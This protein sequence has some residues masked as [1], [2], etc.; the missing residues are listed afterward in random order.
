MFK[1]DYI[2]PRASRTLKQRHRTSSCGGSGAS[3]LPSTLTI[4]VGLPLLF[5][6]GAVGVADEAATET[7]TA[8]VTPTEV[9][10][11]E[12]T[13]ES[14]EA[15]ATKVV[16]LLADDASKIWQHFCSKPEVKLEDVW[17]IVTV[18][19]ERHLICKGDPK[20]FLYTK[21]QYDNFEL[22]FEWT[23][24]SDPNGNSGVL[25]Y[26]QKELRLW[27]TS[28]QVQLHQPEAGA[29]FASGD[30][31]SD[32]PFDA[33]VSAKPAEW[34][35]CRIVS[36]GGRLSVEI[37]GQKAGQTEGCKPNIGF[38]GL[39]SEGSETHFRKLLLKPIPATPPP[40]SPPENATTESKVAPAPG[41]AG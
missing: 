3:I 18:G 17:Q 29:L 14:P 6:N 9:S 4:L 12:Q 36:Q 38:I 35:K 23:Y 13:P 34:N 1:T 39:Q 28:M 2:P 32:K 24:P 30:A 40:A 7:K 37:N 15:A 19:K 20:G 31:T 26:T 5:V 25:I 16:D 21:K 11:E 41:G 27:P 33:G 8:A 22:T 10:G